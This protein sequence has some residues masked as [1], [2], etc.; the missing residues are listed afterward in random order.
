MPNPIFT[1]IASKVLGIVERFMDPEQYE[2]VRMKRLER[3]NEAGEKYIF[4][5]EDDTLT[6]K[7]RTKLLKRYRTRF[8]K[9]N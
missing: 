6:D 7:E 8:F 1:T 9:Y 4:A 5:N 2:I 3:A